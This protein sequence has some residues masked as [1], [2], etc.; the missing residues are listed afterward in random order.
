MVS[1]LGYK[2]TCQ[3]LIVVDEH[4][5]MKS[6]D[7]LPH[8]PSMDIRELQ[9]IVCDLKRQ[10]RIKPVNGDRPS[11]YDVVESPDEKKKLHKKKTNNS[12][13]TPLVFGVNYRAE[14]IAML[15]RQLDKMGDGPDRDLMI[16]LIGDLRC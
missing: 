13:S 8:L 16:G 12:K 5:P 9:K 15:E 2:K 6:R 10:G 14:K 7:M 4:G 3:V 1:N 11:A